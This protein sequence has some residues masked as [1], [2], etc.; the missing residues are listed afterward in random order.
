[1]YAWVESKNLAKKCF[2]LFGVAFD[3]IASPSRDI[4]LGKIRVM[5]ILFQWMP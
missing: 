3:I 2:D 1:M 4:N 5:S